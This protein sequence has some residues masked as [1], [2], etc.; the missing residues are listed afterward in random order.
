MLEY[1]HEY[2]ME[3]AEEEGVSAA[4]YLRQLIESDMGGPPR[5]G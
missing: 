3:R 1:Q 5:A 4:E 2:L